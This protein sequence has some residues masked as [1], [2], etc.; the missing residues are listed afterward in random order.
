MVKHYLFILTLGVLSLL[1]R[2]AFAVTA[3][4]W[5]VEKT[6]PDGT[7]I[8]VY[9]RGDEKVHWMESMDGYTLM[10]DD[11]KYVVYAKQDA[12]GNMVP[13]N[14]RYG[15]KS[16]QPPSPK[17]LRY[18][19]DQVEALKQIWGITSDSGGQRSQGQQKVGATTGERKALCVLVGFS[20]RAFGKTVGDYEILFNQ[21]NLY[22]GDGSVKGS[23]RDFFRENSYGQLDFTVTVVGAYTAP[24]TAAYYASN[25]REFATYAANAANA[26]VNYNDF[27]DSGVLETF[28]ILFA[29]YGDENIGNGQQIWSHKWQLASPI[30]LDGVRISVYSCSP[31]LRGSSG[32]NIT[33]IGV[34]CHELSHVFGSPDYYDTGTGAFSGTGSWDLMANGSWNDSGRQPAHINMY[35]KMLYEW[36]TP[37]ALTTQTTITDM[38]PSAMEPVAYT[39]Q[40]NNNGELYVL[41][42]K[43]KTGFDTSLPGHGLL[44]WHVHQ[45]AL[46]GSG[47]NAGHPQQLYPV[48]A[49][50]TT[51]IPNG[52]P[53]SYG[54]INTPGAPF[55]GISNNTSFTH[56]S[57]PTMFTW[58]GL[59]PV[60]KPVTEITEGT[61]GTISF[62]FLDGPTDP[63]TNLEA[64]VTGND[65]R[66]DWTPPARDDIKGYK[67]FRDG[68]LQ[69]STSDKDKV[70]YT[71]IGVPKG[72]YEYCVSAVYELTESD[73]TCIPVTVTT[74]SDEFYLPVSNLQSTVSASDI[75]LSWTAPFTGGWTGIAGNYA[76]AYGY[77]AKVDYFAGTLWNPSDLKGLNEYKISKVK[78]VPL[79]T[80]S[81]GATYAVEIY[82]VPASGNPQLV[83]TQNVAGTLNY[84]GIYNEVT[85]NSPVTIDATKGVIVGMKVHAQYVPVSEGDGYPGR[86]IF[87]DE[88]GWY[89][90]EDIGFALGHNYCLQVYL[91]GASGSPAPPDPNIPANTSFLKKNSNKKLSIGKMVPSGLSQAPPSLTT[92]HIS[93]DGVEIGTSTTTFYADA[94]L[95]PT[96]AYTYCITVEYS[97]GGLSESVCIETKT[98][99]P[100]KPVNNLKAQ[101]AADEVSLTWNPITEITVF[102]EDFENGIP[103]TWRNVDQ[104]GDGYIWGIR[105]SGATPQSSSSAASASYVNGVGPVNPDNWLVTPAITLTANN[106][107][108]YYVNAQ[109]ATW[110]AEHYAVY[111]STSNTVPGTFTKLF[112]ETMTASP[113]KPVNNPAPGTFRSEGPLYVPGA[114]YERTIDLSAYNGQ[115]VYIAF[116]HFNC[117]NQFSLN[118]DNVKI[119]SPL[120]AGAITY[121]VYEEGTKLGD[122]LTSPQY[123]LADVEA[124]THNYCVTAVYSGVNESETTC[125]E[126]TV[127]DPYPPVNNPKAQVT[128]DEVNLSWEPQIN[129]IIFEEGFE[130]GIPAT[131]S[132]VD[133]DG[134]GY[135]WGII[136]SGV[137]PQ[138]I[139]SATSAS[140]VSG[141]GAVTP[142]NWLVTPAITLNVDNELK[143][144][145]SALDVT[146]SAEHYGV[147]ISTSNTVPGTFTKLFEETMTASPGKPVDNPAP[148]TFRSE[149]PL[150]AG[151]WYER[152]IDLSAYN[153]QTVYIAF[154]HF[155][156]SNQYNLNLDN[157][158]IVSPIS[159]SDI[160][161][162]VYEEGLPI[163]NGLTSP[164]YTVSNVAPGTHN[165]CMTAVYYGVNESKAVCVEAVV[166]AAPAYEVTIAT[167]DNGSIASN[168]ASA[169]EDE[170]VT[171][172]ASP[173]AGYEVDEVTVTKTG[174][175]ETSIEV[176][177]SG[178][179]YTFTMPAY[180]VT[181]QVT[182]KKTDAQVLDEIKELLEGRTYTVNQ[183][184]ANTNVQVADWLVLQINNLLLSSG[185]SITADDV[186]IDAFTPAIEGTAATP[187]GTGGSFAFT[188]SLALNA[189]STTTGSISGTITPTPYTP[190]L[191]HEVTIAASDNGSIASDKASAGE[192][193]LVTLTASPDAGYEVDEVTVTKTGDD[194]TSVQVNG[195]GLT[196]T[197][198]MPDYAV[199]VQATFKKTDAQVLDE[200]KE[201]LEGRTYTVNQAV[202][203]TSIQVTDWLVQQINNQILLS[204]VT[205]SAGDVTIG[206]FTAAI[207]GTASAPS[208]TSGSFDFT[209]SLEL[210][211]ASTTTGSLNGTIIPITY[212]P[213]TPEEVFYTLTIPNV[214]G[215]IIN[216]GAGSHAVSENT[217]VTITFQAAEGYSIENMRAY[218]NGTEQT[219]AATNSGGVYELALGY[220]SGNVAIMVDGIEQGSVGNMALPENG[221]LRVVKADG[222]LHVYGLKPGTEF[223]IYSVSGLLIYQGKAIE[224]EQF[225][226]LRDRGFYII[227]SDGSSVKA[228][229]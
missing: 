39:I 179:T 120:S 31:E 144:Y 22:P 201:L 105:Y 166:A 171:L 8:S 25:E 139:S 116:R 145:V 85:L 123:T 162:N 100:Y 229:L 132:N 210:N 126:A 176:N 196:Y 4:P 82:E 149:G 208:G 46:G 143:Y 95:T 66:L 227:S 49:S 225:I 114:W 209:V 117:F 219:L 170:L 21:E 193:E 35:Q 47:S 71:Q 200:I 130:H 155:N 202:A 81:G 17:G 78:F 3:V 188:V 18:S 221:A 199:T 115:T 129:P 68:T 125:V 11:Q 224:T 214:E 60:A 113:G 161:Y 5:P 34:V 207:E 69:L 77:N 203:N 109:D 67:I 93:R 28:H 33:Y 70:T 185:V 73:K 6:Q 197:F 59:Q 146:W 61:N 222:G 160:T 124:G 20:N 37:V 111:I 108:K 121:N 172:T 182:F 84:T 223:R 29:G 27:A 1:A 190:P 164:Q 52:T 195:S 98:D 24:N 51:A 216:W 218:A 91:D 131:W 163:A 50:S 134:D 76:G 19:K 83:Y 187:S 57:T 54:S 198:T 36:V 30:Y 45:A 58:A 23:V 189:A 9:L 150:Y 135:I 181:V 153:G 92:Y 53:A 32:N 211:A 87:H 48:V 7:A 40:A 138:S 159:A 154:R 42:N 226:P 215:L 147:Y 38:P 89:A 12:N 13:S 156:C 44:I 2:D 62:K 107:L 142:D 140:F 213:P 133:Q 186:T 175:D 55:P 152:T 137:T 158:K 74:G 43:Q 72:N 102:A 204:G 97:D 104:D 96:T 103:A 94:G 212:T 80:L 180:A 169:E 112:E 206:A 90:M 168:K 88:S 14:I 174:D 99:T 16:V 128:A 173:D 41:D 64:T 191:P 220:L 106:E 127:I 177:G 56:V 157:V 136:Y 148:G 15:G 122:G 194:E 101:V 151:A 183:A 65:V 165:Y 63:I 192:N 184:V 119:T 205:I 79:E 228:A 141:V 26:D 178:L 167:S 118:L 110:S 217:Y 86:N 10:Y 75:N